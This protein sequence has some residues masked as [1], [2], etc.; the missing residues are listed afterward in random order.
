[1][2]SYHGKIKFTTE[3]APEKFLDTKIIYEEDGIKTSVYRSDKKLP[4]H[5]SS[6]IPKKYKRNAINTDL[7]RGKKIALNFDSELNVIRQKFKRAG[8]PIRFTDS[9]IRQFVEKDNEETM[10]P[11]YLFEIPKNFVS[12]NIPYCEKNENISK[13]FIKKFHKFN[14]MY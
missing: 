4:V 11:S 2:N 12:V 10:I 1:M 13:N 5:W 6:K 14:F 9:V 8:Y 3:V 7:H